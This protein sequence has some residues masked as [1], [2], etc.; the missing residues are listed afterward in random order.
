MGGE[1]PS[2]LHERQDRGRHAAAVAPTNKVAHTAAASD[3]SFSSMAA[4]F[5]AGVHEERGEPSGQG[6]YSNN[7]HFRPP[8]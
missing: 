7:G 8:S 1:E 6:L 2:C 3:A 4:P 5:Q